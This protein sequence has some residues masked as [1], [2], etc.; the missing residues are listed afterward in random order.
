M[1]G[2]SGFSKSNNAVSAESYGR[3]PATETAR[4]VRLPAG[5]VR[6]C[7]QFASGGEW[8][9]SSKFFNRVAYFDTE[10]IAAWQAGEADVVEERGQTLDA[11]LAAW[12]ETQ[13]AAAEK[14]VKEITGCSVKWLEW[15]GSRSHPRATERVATNCTVR[16]AGGKFVTVIFP[17]GH[18]MKK[19]RDTNGFKITDA[20]GRRAFL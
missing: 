1:T 11:A 2:Y 3:F 10:M 15:G 9:H 18:G 6:D 13:K 20:E 7:S 4:I 17:D 12:R 14:P 19:G 5:F 8:H 16:D